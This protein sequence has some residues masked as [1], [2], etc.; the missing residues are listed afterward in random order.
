MHDGTAVVIVRGISVCRLDYTSPEFLL[1]PLKNFFLP[2]SH[3]TT[4][5]VAR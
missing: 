5:Q 3:M 1:K 2:A 4:E